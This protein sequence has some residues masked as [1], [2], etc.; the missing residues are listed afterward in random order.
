MPHDVRYLAAAC[1][2]D[3]ANPTDRTGIAAHVGHM[4][5]MIERGGGRLP[6]VR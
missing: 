5:V 3:F 6:S 2:T 4:L 1:Q